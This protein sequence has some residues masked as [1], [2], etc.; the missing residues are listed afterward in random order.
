VWF[1][2]IAACLAVV[3]VLN[4]SRTG[5]TVVKIGVLGAGQLGR[6]LALA[7]GPL[8]LSLRFLDPDPEA[9]A[10]AFGEHV[11]A[12]FDDE[13]ALARFAQGL[14]AATLE[15]ENVPLSCVQALSSLTTVYPGP[16][17]LAAA[18]DRLSEK[19]LFSG[20]GLGVH[21]YAPVASAAEVHGA[22]SHV[23][24]PAVLKTRS[25]GYDGKGQGVIRS[26]TDLQ[27]DWDR[28]TSHGRQQGE[29]SVRCLVE[30]MVAFERELSLVAVRGRSGEFGAYP[31]VANIHSGGILRTTIAPAP[32]VAPELQRLAEAHA[33]AIMEHLGYVGVLAIEFFDL[34]AGHGTASRLLA[35]EMAPR[36][37]NTGHW[38][39]EGAQTSQ[40]ENHLRA[41][42][43]LPLGS[44]EAR[45]HSV[46]VNLIGSVPEVR[47][48]LAIK[49]AHVH[50]YG[51][52]ARPGRKVGHVTATANDAQVAAAIAARVQAL[53]DRA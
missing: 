20:L 38:T 52:S 19:T 50:I 48:L 44:C 21:A 32:G 9:C 28:I 24:L 7:G 41:V 31:L 11:C 27:A 30:S 35:N 37:H 10:A 47:E 26:D 17:A 2:T 5:A 12:S 34:G 36:V 4:I 40:F 8:G 39:I 22:L 15:F 23:G 43:G 14:D 16:V 25:M 46:M 45:G 6:M 18:Q 33:R 29:A 1:G 42:A 13:A 3:A 51:K 53:V 49:D